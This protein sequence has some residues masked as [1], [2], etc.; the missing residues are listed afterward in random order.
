MP[1]VPTCA[2]TTI[3]CTLGLRCVLSFTVSIVLHGSTSSGLSTPSPPPPPTISCPLFAQVTQCERGQPS[4]NTEREARDLSALNRNKNTAGGRESGINVVYTIFVFMQ[5]RD[6]MLCEAKHYEI[7]IFVP[8]RVAIWI[9]KY[10]LQEWNIEA[11]NE[12]EFPLMNLSIH[13]W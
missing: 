8:N 11:K 6:I 10:S 5:I 9:L 7:N 4:Q 12:I 3:P 1:P 2:C 13:P